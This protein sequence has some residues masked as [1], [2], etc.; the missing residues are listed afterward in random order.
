[1]LSFNIVTSFIVCR[2]FKVFNNIDLF[3]YFTC[4]NILLAWTEVPYVPT[5]CPQKPEDSTR[6]LGLLIDNCEK[7]HVV[8]RTQSVFCARAIMPLISMLTN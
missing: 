2:I 6:S 7:H 5:S 8:L 4:V 3:Y 1:M